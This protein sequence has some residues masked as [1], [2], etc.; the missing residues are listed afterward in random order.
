MEIK[1]LNMTYGKT[2]A[3]VDVNLNI[4]GNKIYGLLGR[5][6][7]G[8]TTLLN[9]ITSKLFA[10]S[11][12][13]SIDGEMVKENDIALNKI[14]Y[15]ME[16][17]LYPEGLRIKKIFLWTKEFYTSF[18]IEYA[19]AL[20]LKF[21]L[22]INKKVK[23]L[24]T[25]YISIFK[26]I[27]TLAS[28]AEVLIF[29]E[30]ILG[31]DANHRD[32]FYKELLYNYSET[33]RTII[34]STHLIDEVASVLENV[35]IIK[36]GKII[37]NKPVE[38]LLESAYMISGESTKVDKYIADKNF[39][40]EENMGKF[41]SVTVLEKMQSKNEE[42]ARALDLEINKAELQKLFISLTN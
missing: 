14:F 28:N 3:L 15:M 39:I 11:G 8:K 41:K 21:G 7:A 23:E 32:R 13:I 27:L 36:E 35:I 20:A 9:L 16:K 5:N 25:G 26:V 37:L 1:G 18:D 19:K 38:E 10:T 2:K 29:D 24:S 6:G 42:S 4:E 31:L 30:P 22:N 17:N 33:P 34:I 12:E 40:G